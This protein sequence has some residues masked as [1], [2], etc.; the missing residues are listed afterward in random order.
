MAVP[1]GTVPVETLGTGPPLI[2]LHGWT[3]DRRMWLPQL[4]L[5]DQFALIGID[6]RGFGQATAP[7]DLAAEPDD[8]LRVAD[9]LGLRRFHVLGMS[10]GGRVALALA[11]RAGS[12]LLSLTLACTALD[13]VAAPD[14]E[15]PIAAMTDAARRGDLGAMR[16]L[17]QRHRLMRPAGQAGRA[18]VAAMLAD[19][20]AR[21]LVVARHELPAIAGMIAALNVPVTAIVGA[22]DTPQ[23][24]ANAAAL[25]KA[26]AGL[27][28]L[29]GGHLCNIDDPHG[30]NLVM[31][32]LV[33]TAGLGAARSTA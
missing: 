11:D 6:R 5:A 31:R 21:D 13:G 19:Y 32:T 18:L 8:V 20:T 17:W 29:A 10:Q 1:G 30:F 9:A 27:V 12:R 7:P 22:D 2:L 15:V 14:E 28:T 26:G 24:L 25:L 4:P 23:R 16:T 3:L 33:A